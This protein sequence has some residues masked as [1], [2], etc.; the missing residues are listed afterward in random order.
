MATVSGFTPWNQK[1]TDHGNAGGKHGGVHGMGAR[2]AGFRVRAILD[3]DALGMSG[4]ANASAYRHYSLRGATPDAAA[5]PRAGGENHVLVYMGDYDSSAWLSRNIPKVWDDP[6][7]A[8]SPW[9]GPSIPTCRIAYHVFDHVFST[10]TDR[11]WFIAATRRGLPEPEPPHGDRLGSGLPDALDLWVRHNQHYYTASTV[12]SW[13]RYQL[14]AT[15][16]W[17][18]SGPTRGFSPAAW[19]CSRIRPAC[20]WRALPAPC[21]D[22]YPNLRNLDGAV[23]ESWRQRTARAQFLIFRMICEASTVRL[24]QRLKETAA[25]GWDRC[26][27]IPSSTSTSNISARRHKRVAASRSPCEIFSPF[28]PLRSLPYLRV[29]PGGTGL[30]GSRRG[31][32]G[33]RLGGL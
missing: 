9:P 33:H 18:S 29:S 32:S 14:P 20:R 16:P 24:I 30:P 2:G 23:S 17:R 26:D 31:G 25:N 1:Y 7:A 28:R 11:D 19:A 6:H 13:L 15:C 10:R 3:A 8:R 21:R 27:P 22:L 12:R 4:L 5:A